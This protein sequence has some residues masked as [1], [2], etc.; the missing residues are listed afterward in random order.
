MYQIDISDN[1]D[2]LPLD[3]DYLTEVV[4]KTL[5][6]EQVAAAS[7]SIAIVDNPT[8]HELNRQYLQHDY[9]TDVLSFLLEETDNS[10]HTPEQPRGTGKQIDGEVIVS[11]EYAQSLAADYDWAP[12]HELVLYIV[13]GVLHLCGYDD[14]TAEELPLM[15]EREQ[16][17]FALLNLPLPQR[18]DDDQGHVDDPD[19]A[20]PA[21]RPTQTEPPPGGHS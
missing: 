5:E 20:P 2:C 4:R 9:E 17:V 3:A 6:A 19:F 18:D 11:A 15:R 14:L 13:H 16:A 21:E 7:L 10:Q 1:Q 12:L 8:I